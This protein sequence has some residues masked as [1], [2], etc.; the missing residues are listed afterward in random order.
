[1]AYT[2]KRA[3]EK[4]IQAVTKC[5]NSLSRAITAYS[6]SVNKLDTLI[7][8]SKRK[9]TDGK[10]CNSDDA[11]VRTL[12]VANRNKDKVRGEITKLKGISPENQSIDEYTR[13]YD[14]CTEHLDEV[15]KALVAYQEDVVQYLTN[16]S[17]KISHRID[18]PTLFGGGYSKMA[19]DFKNGITHLTSLGTSDSVLAPFQEKVPVWDKVYK[20]QR[21][22]ILIA[23][24]ILIIF[25]GII[26]FAICFPVDFIEMIN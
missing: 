13:Q 7:Q 20:R 26:L 21:I 3:Q 4:E 8:K 22:F 6:N 23:R 2:S 16:L 9:I 25:G 5:L 1:M 19:G 14:E 17:D 11:I 15:Q 24:W 12:K 10:G 18:N